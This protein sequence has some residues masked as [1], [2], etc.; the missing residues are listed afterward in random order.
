MKPKSTEKKLKKIM[1]E[2]GFSHERELESIELIAEE[3]GDWMDGFLKG[4]EIAVKECQEEL[5]KHLFPMLHKMNS[6]PSDAVPK[7]TILEL[8]KLMGL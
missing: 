5:L 6:Y 4:Y 3:D 2:Y 7:A 1:P 8:D